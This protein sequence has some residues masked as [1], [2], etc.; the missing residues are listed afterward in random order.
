M[1]PLAIVP[2]AML[3]L[4]VVF[5][6]VVRRNTPRNQSGHRQYDEPIAFGTGFLSAAAIMLILVGGI[7]LVILVF[8]HY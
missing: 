7:W 8:L 2:L 1:F 6:A 5:V 4:G 3:V